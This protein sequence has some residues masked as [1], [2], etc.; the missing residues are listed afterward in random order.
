MSKTMIS[1]R[2]DESLS[3]RIEAIAASTK[4]SKAFLLAEALEG[5]V[6]KHERLQEAIKQAE[7]EADQSGAFI[8][9]GKMEAWLHSLGTPDELPLPDPDVF[10]KKR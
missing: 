7:R 2:I 3:G 8:S 6:E 10:R 4:R 5:L 9:H 1:A